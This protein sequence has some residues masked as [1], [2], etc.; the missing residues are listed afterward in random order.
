MLTSKICNGIHW[1]PQT[2]TEFIEVRCNAALFHPFQ[3][4]AM[5]TI[6]IVQGYS[7]EDLQAE[8]NRVRT[9]GMPRT[10]LYGW[11]RRLKLI[12]GIDGLYTQEDLETLKALNRFLQRWGMTPFMAIKYHIG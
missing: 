2:I 12:P 4:C 11:I 10:T 6:Q 5:N 3:R 7:F 8:L 1:T 9:G